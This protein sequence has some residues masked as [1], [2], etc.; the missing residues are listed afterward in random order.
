M[1]I[2]DR[3]GKGDNRRHRRG[4]HAGPVGRV[5]YNRLVR[6]DQGVQAQ[7]AQVEN[8]YQRRADLVPNL[9]ETVKGAANFE[10]DDLH[11]RD[12][13][14]RAAS[15]RSR[16]RRPRSSPTTRRRSSEFQQAQDGLSSALSRLLVVSE[17]YPDLKA[18][19]GFR[20]L[21]AQL[22]GT[23]NRIAVERMRFNEAA[24][25]FNTARDS[26]PDRRSSPACSAATLH[27]EGVL[28]GAGRRGDRASGPVL[29]VGGRCRASR[30]VA[31]SRW[32]PR[33]S[34][35]RRRRRR[36]AGR[37]A[38]PAGARRAG[39]PIARRSLGARRRPDAGRAPRRA[40]RSRP[41]TRSSSTSTTR[42]AACR[43]R[44]GRVARVRALARRP[45][46]HRRRRRAV[47]LRDDHR[48]ASRSGY[49]LEDRVPDA[50]ASRIIDEEMV[51]RASAPATATAPSAPA[52]T[53]LIAAIG[54]ARRRGTSGR[55][56]GARARSVVAEI[57]GGGLVLIFILGFVVTHPSLALMLLQHRVARR[58]LAAA[59][60]VAAAAA[61]ASPA[62]V[63]AR[64]AAA[65]RGRGDDGAPR[66]STAS[67]RRVERAIARRR[68]R[69]PPARSASRSR[70]SISGATCGAPPSAPSRAWAWTARA[71]TTAC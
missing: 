69:A 21:Q 42:P 68:A 29:T 41:A 63:A 61:A 17:R 48:C 1:P 40:T 6:L 9:V 28:Q 10:K 22:E 18:T 45:Q 4:R 56:T 71:S 55:A 34:R 2:F 59:A 43:S 14:A 50:V 49:G 25:A 44:T 47:H 30:R 26:F 31:S 27:R 70:A 66:V 13:G 8:V 5:D 23:E 37:D 54:G 51:P 7:W 60:G 19:Q 39:S 11:R 32:S 35:W 15:A 53:R 64:A 3:N 24:Q 33:R 46:G 62:A 12:R 16:R 57:V 20:D 52:S 67:T 38:D 58:R 36:R 65:P